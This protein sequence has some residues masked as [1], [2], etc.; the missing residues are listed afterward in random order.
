MRLLN[1]ILYG[2][3]AGYGIVIG[4]SASYSG[5]Y[6]DVYGNTTDEYSGIT[7]PT[8]TSGNISSDPDFASITDD[9]DY[10]ND[11]WSLSTGSA[12][13]NTGNS[14]AAYDDDDGTRNDMGA[15]GGPGGS[16]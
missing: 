6:S 12:C 5:S 2:A 1:S 9:G 3:N 14:S 11:D 8:G 4:S 15:F 10:T 13:I 16:W 7:D